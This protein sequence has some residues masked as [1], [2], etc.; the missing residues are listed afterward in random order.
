MK[1]IL[2]AALT[3]SALIAT[4]S[5]KK[6]V[7][8]TPAEQGAITL[9]YGISVNDD[10]TILSTRAMSDAELLESAVIEIYKPAFEGMARRYV[11]ASNI[12]NPIYLPATTGTD[13]YRVDVKAGEAVK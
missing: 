12:P 10:N 6:D 4:T 3:M 5:C 1:K 2:F 9:S 7:T 8:E 13:K 11:G